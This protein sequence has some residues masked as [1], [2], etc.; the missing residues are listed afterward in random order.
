MNG[1]SGATLSPYFISQVAAS[2]PLAFGHITRGER[3]H[4][5]IERKRPATRV[6]VPTESMGHTFDVFA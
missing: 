5:E 2:H 1:I 3:A 4:D 6:I